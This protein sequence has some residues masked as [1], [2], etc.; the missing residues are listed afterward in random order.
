[1]V[2]A[3]IGSRKRGAA[4]S[5]KVNKYTNGLNREI[6]NRKSTASGRQSA[7]RGGGAE[8]SEREAGGGGPG[9]RLRRT[10][11]AV[12]ALAYVLLRRVL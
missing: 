2:G 10:P 5:S 3:W 9:A 6:D 1:M 12:L 4:T 11:G 7:E 8:P